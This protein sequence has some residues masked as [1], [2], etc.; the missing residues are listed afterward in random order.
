MEQ[1]KPHSP[2]E[3]ES[4]ELARLGGGNRWGVRLTAYRDAPGRTPAIIRPTAS[5]VVVAA[6]TMSMISPS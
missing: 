4:I 3:G 1:S 2:L 5:R 6:S